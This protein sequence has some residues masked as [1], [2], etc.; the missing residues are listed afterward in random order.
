MTRT[1]TAPSGRP[2]AALD[3]DGVVVLEHPEVPVERHSVSAYGR[4][5]RQ[6]LVPRV[7]PA[8]LARLSELFDCVWVSAWSHTAHPALREAL[9]L[10]EKEWPWMGAQFDKLPAIRDFAAGRPWVWIDEGIDDLG[11]WPDPPDGLLARVR[12]GHGLADVD[13][14]ELFDKLRSGAYGAADLPASPSAY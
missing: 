13:P 10:P 11:A 1:R 14:E 4:W 2:V 9:G 12:P 7:A 5:R 6:V 3:V 8:R